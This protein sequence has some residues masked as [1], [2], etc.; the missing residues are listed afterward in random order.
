MVSRPGT[1]LSVSLVSGIGLLLGLQGVVRALVFHPSFLVEEVEVQWKGEVVK[2]MPDRYRLKPT[3][4]IFEIN[5]EA[6]RRAL[7][8]RHSTAEV[9]VVQR[10]LPNRVV[11]TLRLKRGVA[12]VKADRYYPI[13]E[14]GTV[15]SPGQAAPWPHLPALFLEEVKGPFR[16]GTEIEHPNFQ[17]ICELL[18]VIRRQGGIGGHGVGSLRSKGKELTLFLDS[19]LEIRF[20]NHRLGEDWGRLTE[21]V[22]QRPTV[23]NEAQYLDLRFKDPVV[24]GK[25]LKGGKKSSP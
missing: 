23:L 2:P 14:E 1:I 11:A 4:S 9:E 13:S 7:V 25:G 22:A 12:Q 15:L 19:G 3:T 18:S 24:G 20:A 5:L 17:V 16:V 6:L 8:Q 10:I 21:L